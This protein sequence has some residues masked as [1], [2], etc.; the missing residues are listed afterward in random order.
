MRGRQ[1]REGR[2]LGR[3]AREGRREKAGEGGQAREGRR[4]K[5][6]GEGQARASGLEGWGGK[7][8]KEGWLWRG[9]LWRGRLWRGRLWRGRL[10]RGRLARRKAG[11]EDGCGDERQARNA[12]ARKAG[13]EG[14]RGR[15]SPHHPA[16]L[17]LL[18][19]TLSLARPKVD[20]LG[21]FLIRGGGGGVTHRMSR[22]LHHFTDPIF[23]PSGLMARAR[24]PDRIARAPAPGIK[25]GERA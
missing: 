7:A 4:G 13:E 1:A 18:S 20:S 16:R 15:L 14:R 17:H 6:G 21:D 12:V 5:A 23:D 2:H 19:G 3:Q 8:N 22:F 24:N 11:E 25:S 9:R 10:W